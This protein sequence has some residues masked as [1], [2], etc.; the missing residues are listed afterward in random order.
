MFLTGASRQAVSR[1]DR[2][3]AP[4][5]ALGAL[6]GAELRVAELVAD[7]LSNT[8]IADALHVSRHT[9]ESHL[10]HSFSKLGIDSRVQLA[11]IVMGS[12]QFPV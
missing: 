1:R 8:A 10:K 3:V 11:G 5:D 6:T 9:V 12:H 7:G 4:H 2:P